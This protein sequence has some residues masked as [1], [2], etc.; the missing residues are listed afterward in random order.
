MLFRTKL[1]ALGL[2]GCVG[3]LGCV[4]NHVHYQGTDGGDDDATVGPD[5]TA[6]ATIGEDGSIDRDGS[7]SN[8]EASISAASLASDCGAEAPGLG[9]CA[10]PPEKCM[11]DEN[12]PECKNWCGLPCQQSNMQLLLR[13]ESTSD[14]GKVSIQKVELLDNS[15]NKVLQELTS[16]EPKLWNGESY[17][18]WDENLEAAATPSQVSY[19]LTAPDWAT[20]GSGDA[21]KTYSMT[22][23]LRVTVEV[24]GVSITLL[25]DEI[26]REPE[27]VT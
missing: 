10:P 20:I 5:A 16:Y 14:A 19:N 1:L 7:I 12:D 3:L 23:Y 22:F 15:G 18:S 17:A 27:I 26:M 21:W 25:S 4:E 24:D 11:Q 9:D 13:A 2:F 8:L 6:D